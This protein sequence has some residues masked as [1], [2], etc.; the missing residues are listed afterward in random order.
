MDQAYSPSI[1]LD[2]TDVTG[3]ISTRSERI[4]RHDAGVFANWLLDEGL[5]IETLH[6]LT[7][8]YLIAC[9]KYLGDTYAKATA[10]RMFSVAR[11]TLQEYVHRGTLATN[12]ATG[13]KTFPVAN[14]T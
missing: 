6:C 4:Y 5:T 11:R 8:S 3:Q 1:T 2:I 9:R 13:I 10:A 12:P 14:E 7:R